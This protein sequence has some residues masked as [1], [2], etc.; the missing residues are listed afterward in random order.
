MLLTYV[1]AIVV[2]ILIAII[3]DW[4]SDK[5][6]FWGAVKSHWI[7]Y[8]AMAFGGWFLVGWLLSFASVRLIVACLAA[9]AIYFFWTAIWN[10][11]KRNISKTQK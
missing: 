2:L 3:L 1:V 11:I 4:Q 9:I 5:S 10:A 8:A 7:K 6:S